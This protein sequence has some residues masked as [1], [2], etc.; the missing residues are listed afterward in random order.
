MSGKS[1]SSPNLTMPWVC[2]P[3]TS[4][5]VHFRVVRQW[6]ASI[7]SFA[8]F[9]SRYSSTNFISDSSLNGIPLLV[10][11][12]TAN[13]YGRNCP[14]SPGSVLIQVEIRSSKFATSSRQSCRMRLYRRA[15][16]SASIFLPPPSRLLTPRCSAN[17]SK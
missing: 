8:I 5:N 6:I 15:A 4:I 10:L 3:Q 16:S 12:Y 13:T 14:Y 9:P 1:L 7:Y 2:P 17:G 11:I